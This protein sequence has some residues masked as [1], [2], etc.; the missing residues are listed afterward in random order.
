MLS[1]QAV[2]DQIRQDG[3]ENAVTG[4]GTLGRDRAQSMAFQREAR[5]DAETLASLFRWDDLCNRVVSI[6][7][8]EALRR[9]VATDDPATDAELKRL[10]AR[11]K[12]LEGATWGRL[13]GGAI[14]VMGLPGD[15]ETPASPG[16][17]AWLDV[18]DRRE[19]ERETLVLDPRSPDYLGSEIF[20]V[21]PIAGGTFRVHRSRCLVFGGA[22]TGARER[23]ENQGWDDSVLEIVIKVI[24]DFNAGHMALGNMLTDASQGIWKV[25]GLIGKLAS[26]EGRASL[27]ERATL[28]D[29][30]RGITRSIMLD[31]DRN[32]DFRKEATTFTGVPESLDRL[33]NRL[34][35]ATE[36]PVTVLMGQA[37]AGLNAT[38]DA[39]LRAWYDRIESYRANEID[40]ILARL[41][42]A[43]GSKAK[44]DWPSL[45]QPTDAERAAVQ[46]LEAETTAIEIQNGVL[47]PEE[48]TAARYTSSGPVPIVADQSL[49]LPTGGSAV[50]L[51]PSDAAS[52]VTVNEARASMG[53]GPLPEPDGSMSLTEY[54]TTLEA[55][56]AAPALP[57]PSL[58]PDALTVDE[59]RR[60]DG[61]EPL[62]GELG[63]LTLAEFRARH[64][65]RSVVRIGATKEG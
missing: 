25:A 22:L 24:R 51:T 4:L 2:I 30:T 21:S 1:V 63:G 18:Y 60:A 40:P 61:R 42:L 10:D 57:V 15:P 19:V 17:V 11:R 59:A 39:D 26:K 31:A 12:I 62:G 5:A 7:P 28:L 50:Q 44:T 20:R 54:R 53:L 13:Y 37:P 14:A 52:V 27:A 35:A 47:L 32:E 16:R 65:A 33:A 58:A 34:S 56:G 45:W 64:S 36:I 46:K 49:R 41:L 43:M 29:L 3:W 6:F 38:G 9:G 23:S 8:R 55:Q 48:V